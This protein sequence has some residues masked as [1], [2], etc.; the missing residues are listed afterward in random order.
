MF[1][2]SPCQLLWGHQMR[3]VNVGTAPHVVAKWHNYQMCR[4]NRLMRAT[5]KLGSMSSSVAASSGSP[6]K[7][8]HASLCG[9][10]T[11]L[12]TKL[13]ASKM[14]G[15]GKLEQ[16]PFRDTLALVQQTPR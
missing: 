9:I 4:W 13:K 10:A 15:Y 2:L 7:P 5:Y 1:K 3:Q 11:P 8:L 12:S 14:S 16:Y 6:T